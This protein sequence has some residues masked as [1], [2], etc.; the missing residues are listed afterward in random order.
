[1]VG[2][3]GGSRAGECLFPAGQRYEGTFDKGRAPARSKGTW[4]DRHGQRFAVTMG[5][6]AM[7]WELTGSDNVFAT[8]ERVQ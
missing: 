3:G 7:M 8:R 6:S 1:M 5:Q 2:R 4:T